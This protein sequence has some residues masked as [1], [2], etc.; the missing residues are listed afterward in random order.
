[1]RDRINEFEACARRLLTAHPPGT[2]RCHPRRKVFARGLCRGCYDHHAHHG[3]LH[4]HERINRPAEHFVADY[5]LLRS[6]GFSRAQ[7]AARLGMRRNTADKAY[8][9]AVAAGLLTPDRAVAR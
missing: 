9:R 8:R 3:T 5:V 4:H 6:E 1:M 7:I 2:A